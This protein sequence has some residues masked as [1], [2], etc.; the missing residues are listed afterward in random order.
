MAI[1][2]AKKYAQYETL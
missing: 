1:H 2:V